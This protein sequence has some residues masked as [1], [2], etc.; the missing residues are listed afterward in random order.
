MKKFSYLFTLLFLAG[1][2]IACPTKSK[3]NSNEWIIASLV[4]SS[5]TDNM[6]GTISDST[7]K[8]M[9]MKCAIGQVYN[10]SLNN[11]AGAGGGTTYAAKS[12]SWCTIDS[13]CVGINLQATSGPAFDACAALTFGGHTNW[14]LPTKLELT[15]LTSGQTRDNYLIYFPQTPDDK[16]FWT[17]EQDLK[18]AKSAYGVNFAQNTFGDA[19]SYDKVY[20][21]LYVRCVR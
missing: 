17:A 20:G 3:S 10:S 12:V 1:W 19:L 8:L 6:N 7:S 5:L 21:Q 14:R 11:C 2:S 16:S 9:W 15:G 4:S 18:T 13:G